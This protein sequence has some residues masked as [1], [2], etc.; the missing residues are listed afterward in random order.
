MSL[1]GKKKDQRTKADNN[2]FKT[3]KKGGKLIYILRGNLKNKIKNKSI[4]YLIT[5]MQ[6]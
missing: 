4:R 3:K 2:K 1:H 5:D 6:F